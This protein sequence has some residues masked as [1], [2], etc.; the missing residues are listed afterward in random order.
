VTSQTR[1]SYSGL[2]TRIDLSLTFSSAGAEGE[3]PIPMRTVRYQPAVDSKNVVRR[4]PV[5]VLP[6]RLDTLPGATSPAV[7]KLEIQVSGDD[8]VTWKKASVVR[9]GSGYKAIFATP[10]GT[11]VSLKAHLVDAGGN[12][13]DQT[14]IAAYPLG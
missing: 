3:V 2:S 4:T 8:G 11:T 7:R 14:T 1:P 6:V 9:V 5:T 13:T 12:S 10:K